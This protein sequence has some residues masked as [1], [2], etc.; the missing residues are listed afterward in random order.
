MLS[1]SRFEHGIHGMKAKSSFRYTRF[2]TP[3]W[4]VIYSIFNCSGVFPVLALYYDWLETQSVTHALYGLL[5]RG[6]VF[7]N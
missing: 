7:R 4:V 2:S 6:G 3:C 5:L 1:Q